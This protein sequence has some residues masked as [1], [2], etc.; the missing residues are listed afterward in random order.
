M[1]Y[2]LETEIKSKCL[3][4]FT[5]LPFLNQLTIT[6]SITNFIFYTEWK[7]KKKEKNKQTKQKEFAI[8]MLTSFGNNN[9]N[10]ILA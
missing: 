3:L 5:P 10:N 8:H 9:N 2:L 6:H 7:T 4:N 1:I